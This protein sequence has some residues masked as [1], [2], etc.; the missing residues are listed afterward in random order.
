M[1]GITVLIYSDGKYTVHE[2]IK[3]KYHYNRASDHWWSED[4]KLKGFEVSGGKFFTTSHKT[5]EG[6]KREIDMRKRLTVLFNRLD[7]EREE[8]KDAKASNN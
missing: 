1:K 8:Y 7:K 4:V 6:A 3:T 2:K 5:L